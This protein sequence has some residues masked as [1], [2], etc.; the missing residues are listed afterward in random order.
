MDTRNF[1]YDLY[2]ATSGVW[3]NVDYRVGAVTQAAYGTVFF[4]EI[5]DM[6]LDAQSRLLTFFNDLKARV[7]GA[8]PFFTYAHVVAATNRDLEHGVG[9]GSFRHDLLA[10]FRIRV[11]LPPLRHRSEPDMR[12]LID[13]TAQNPLVNP[14]VGP[15]GA[16]ATDGVLLVSHISQEAMDRLAQHQ[17]ADGNFREMEEAV[18]NSIWRARRAND[19]TVRLEH[20]D[21]RPQRFRPEAD[22]RVIR[23]RDIA[24]ASANHVVFVESIDELARLASIRNQSILRSGRSYSVIDGAVVYRFDEGDAAEP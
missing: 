19:H 21:V 24:P 2:G 20:V 23:V 3:H 17:Y 5:G 12:R 14:R 6:P 1:D 18:H 8:Q 16:E 15:S 10:R 9:R 4:D 22:A 11:T 7:Q 13:F